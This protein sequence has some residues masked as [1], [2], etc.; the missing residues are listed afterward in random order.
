LF[1]ALPEHKIY[2]YI[3]L[4]YAISVA[5]ATVYGRYHY[6]VDAVAGIAMSLIALLLVRLPHFRRTF[7]SA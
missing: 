5:I 3:F 4:G 2:G 6:A 7:R 1:A